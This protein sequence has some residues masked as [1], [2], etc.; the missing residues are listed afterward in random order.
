ME[1]GISW[2]DWT[3]IAVCLAF[4]SYAAVSASRYNR[5]VADFLAA[6][7]CAGRYLLGI[8]ERE[9]GMGVVT[10]I[11]AFEI[12]YAS[13]F[14]KSFWE[15]IGIPLMLIMMF[16]GWVIYRYRQTRAMTMAQFFEMR[17]SR[18]FRIFAGIVSWVAGVI[19]FGIF[20]G[21]GARFFIIFLNL[22]DVVSVGGIGI[23]TFPMVMLFLIGL[24]L[25]FTFI[26]G[27]ISILVTDFWQGIIAGIV[28]LAVVLFLWCSFSWADI[29]AAL[30]SA[31]RPGVSLID[32]FD[33]SDAKDFNVVFFAIVWIM[34]FYQKHAWQGS[35]GY[36][37]SAATPHEAKMSQ[38][39]GALRSLM[40]DIGI[41]LMPLVAL[42]V[43]NNPKFA[44]LAGLCGEQL[45]RRFPGDITLQTQMRTPVILN[46]LLPR[47]FIGCFAAA[48][49]GFFISSTNTSL[50][51]WGSIF[52]QD[53]L[54]PLRKEPFK[55]GQHM[56]YLRVSIVSVAV[57]GFL[58][59]ILFPLKDYIFMFFQITAAIYLGGAGVVIIGGLYWPRG[60]VAG[61]WAAMITGAVLALTGI[62][63]QTI[64]E[65]VPAWV[66]YSE[67]FPLNGQI[68]GF[69]AAA[70]AVMAY[71]LVSLFGKKQVVDMDRILNRG[72]YADPE[73]KERE[74]RHEAP[75][76]NRFWTFIGVNSRE[77]S[78][79]D[80]LLFLFMFLYMMYNFAAII[81]LSVFHFTGLM[82]EHR[83]LIWWRL[84]L[85]VNLVISLISVVWVSIG[86]FWDL[87]KM[88]QRLRR[89]VRDARDDGWIDKEKNA[90][91]QPNSG[92][93]PGQRSV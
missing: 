17:Y 67:K 18:K 58:F 38:V 56:R 2:I 90:Q 4:V 33:I 3:I 1:N 44:E 79:I 28:F 45:S 14:A 89:I 21:V 31:S 41:I 86:G 50:H 47:G 19:N 42:T 32:P 49:L 12:F 51:S 91:E 76:I 36:Q 15:K 63:V 62:T 75:K 16:S 69:F 46:H 87:R 53:I 74:E 39:V 64:W 9:A 26:G 81:V 6:N 25:F 7:R 66:A 34:I 13:G 5:G 40:I 57:F 59:S 72:A 10:V 29:S 77:F 60:T 93:A 20:P 85:S 65:H 37:C 82:N 78:R 27:Q 61:A 73:E 92:A 71:V 88:L 24:A 54:M 8:A 68:M 30:V 43:M 48:M 55:P 22:P 70:A 84:M 35:Q 23:P 83:W 11:L 52:V 80:K